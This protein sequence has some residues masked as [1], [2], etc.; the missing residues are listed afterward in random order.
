MKN[1]LYTLA[2]A[3][4]LFISTYGQE[5]IKYD[6]VFF[7]D[8][9]VETPNA[10]ITLSNVVSESDFIKGKVKVANYTDKALLIKPEECSYTTPIGDIPSKD[11]WMVISPRQQ[12]SKTI[13]VKGDNVKT[14]ETTLKLNGFYICNTVEIITA[15]NMPLP[16]EKDIIIGG[17][18]LEL[19][20]WDRDGK[21]I[22]IRY[23]V[24][25]MGDKVGMFD[26]GKV[27]LKSPGGEYKNQKDKDK[28]MAFQKKEE[29]LVGF[30]YLSDSKKDNILEWKDAFSE[31][32]PEKLEAVNVTVKIDLP[33]TKEKN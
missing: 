30:V 4:T 3:S 6:K 12:E 11:K 9:S 26:P 25:Y 17:F 15:Q 32:T 29:H 13:D 8:N 7:E 21:E 5:K 18:K 2:T 10:K 16:P 33:K 23:R 19:D 27:L 14:T 31:G 22:M 1:Y 28:V 24:Q 20:T